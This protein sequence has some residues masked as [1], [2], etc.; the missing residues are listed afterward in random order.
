MPTSH[1]PITDGNLEISVPTALELVRLNLACLIDVR[2]PFELE[3]QGEIASAIALPWFHL[4]KLLGHTLTSEDQEMLDADPPSQP[5]TQSV[6]NL[7]NG[8]HYDK[9]YI[10]I[11]VCLKGQR[12]LY[13]AQLFRALGYPRTLSLRGGYW[14]F[15][16]L[17]E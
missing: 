13:A 16:E 12:S 4:K 15:K 7:L 9:H 8:L 10:L 14:A 5:D 6:F 17:D 1:Q 2:Q 3:T 11:C